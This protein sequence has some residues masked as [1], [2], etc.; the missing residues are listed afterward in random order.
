MP[1]ILIVDDNPQDRRLA[2]RGLEQEFSTVTIVEAAN[3]EGLMTA[4]DAAPFDLAVTDFRL[5]WLDGLEV[6]AILKQRF[7]DMPVVMFTDSGN[8]EVA[9]AG[10]RG[11]LSDYILKGPGQYARLAHGVRRALERAQREQAERDMLDREHH[12]RRL[13]EDANRLKDQFLAT[14]SHELRTPLN[15]TAGWIQTLLVRAGDVDHVRRCAGRADR[16]V[17]LLGRII[18]DLTDVSRI[19]AGKL[20]LH[21]ERVLL[22]DIVRAAVE[23]TE[24]A[25]VEKAVT[26]AVQTETEDAVVIGD[27]ERLQ[28]L[29]VNLVANAIKFTPSGGRITVA[30]G[31]DE[32]Y[33]TLRV[34]DT[35]Q[36]IT[37]EFLG[38]L[39]D[40]FAQ[41]D[42]G[43]TRAQ[44][45]LGLGLALVQELARLHGGSVTAESA[46]KGQGATFTVRLPAAVA[47][48]H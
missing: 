31:R 22:D 19:A 41:E 23:T 36:G 27:A 16:N 38:R 3:R 9:A 25:A 47:A 10:F 28:Q 35:G 32:E 1:R 11:G 48:T 5:H 44:A 2:A 30:I 43:P 34:H 42:A 26:I 21:P 8:E 17:R 24:A 14:L 20:S 12:A 39:F 15:A 37:P 29:V 4:L 6:L 46:G 45:G 40:R 33:V 13:A 7:P 18:D